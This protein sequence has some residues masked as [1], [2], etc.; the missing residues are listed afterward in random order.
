MGVSGYYCLDL[1]FIS[2]KAELNP[3][4]ESLQ[5]E[6]LPRNPKGIGTQS[7]GVYTQGKSGLQLPRKRY[8]DSH[9][10]AGGHSSRDTG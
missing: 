9:H 4:L 10:E 8:C 1:F 7:G 2:E 3:A 6:T 5:T